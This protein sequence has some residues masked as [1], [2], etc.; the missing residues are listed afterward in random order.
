MDKNDSGVGTYPLLE[1]L[2]NGFQGV[3]DCDT[4]HISCG[5]FKTEREVQGDLFD[6]GYAQWQAQECWVVD[7]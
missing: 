3:L 7:C 1:L 4:L 2:V 6:L 5:N